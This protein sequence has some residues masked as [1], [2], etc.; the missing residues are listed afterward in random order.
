MNGQFLGSHLDRQGKAWVYSSLPFFHASSST[1]KKSVSPYF[2]FID[3]LPKG[4]SERASSA[5]AH[6]LE[7]I[8][9]TIFFIEKFFSICESAFDATVAFWGVGAIE[10]GNVLIADVAEPV[11]TYLLAGSSAH[12]RGKEEGK[13]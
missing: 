3:F 13:R 7:P 8:G 9:S 10:V 6:H 11:D 2:R 1:L 4:V 5:F 12:E